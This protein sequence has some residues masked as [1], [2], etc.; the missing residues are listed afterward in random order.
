MFTA[1]RLEKLARI[2]RWHFWFQGRRAVLRRML[3]ASLPTN[4]RLVMDIGCG[5]GHLLQ[6]L[7]GDG[8]QVLGIDLRIEGLR[9]T[10]ARLSGA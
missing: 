6:M 1:S 4:A 5:T 2:E 7:D 8:R 9:S 3:A 10:R